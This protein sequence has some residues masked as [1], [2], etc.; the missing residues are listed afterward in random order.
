MVRG[1]LWDSTRLIGHVPPPPLVPLLDALYRA[2]LSGVA[3]PHAP[4]GDEPGGA[5]AG[6]ADDEPDARWTRR[7]RDDD[8]AHVSALARRGAR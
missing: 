5:R 4:E 1:W 3:V 8:A 2:R 6:D 7:R